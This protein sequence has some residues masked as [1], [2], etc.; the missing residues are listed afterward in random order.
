MRRK[1]SKEAIRKQIVTDEL[2]QSCLE[3]LERKFY[4]GREVVF[5]KDRD[6]LLEWVVLWPAHYFDE[7]AVT[8][9]LD[10]YREIIMSVFMD[11]AA[12]KKQ[13]RIIYLPAYR[14]TWPKSSR[15]ISAFMARTITALPNPSAPWPIMLSFL[16]SGMSLRLPIP[17]VKW[18]PPTA[19]LPPKSS[20]SRSKR[21]QKK[22]S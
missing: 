14:L 8:I 1:L 11:A 17:S 5:K 3:F 6:K 15:A 20:K 10:Q 19:F 9:G 21:H 12:F 16:P 13:S 7:K 18:Q 22:T 4:E 2:C